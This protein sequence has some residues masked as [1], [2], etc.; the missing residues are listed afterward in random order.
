MS[1]K[2]R[3]KHKGPV[4]DPYNYGRISLVVLGNLATNFGDPLK[5]LLFPDEW[6]KLF[7]FDL[8]HSINKNA[9]MS[10][11]DKYRDF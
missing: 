9:L 1:G 10:G 7:V 6:H 11:H 3:E 4:H 8:D 2:I 5:D